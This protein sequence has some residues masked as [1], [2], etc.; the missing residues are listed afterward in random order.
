MSRLAQAQASK[1][2]ALGFMPPKLMSNPRFM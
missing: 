1:A 2:L